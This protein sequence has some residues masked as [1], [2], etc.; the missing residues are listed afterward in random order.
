MHRE[1]DRRDGGRPRHADERRGPPRVDVL[2]QQLRVG[3]PRL[4]EAQP[5]AGDRLGRG[6]VAQRDRA[7][8]RPVVEHARDREEVG[9]PV[10]DRDVV[11]GG[12][13]R[14][15]RGELD[16]GRVVAGQDAERDDGRAPVLHEA[17]ARARQR[18]AGA[19]DGHLDDGRARLRRRQVLQGDRARVSP[20]VADHRDH[21]VQHDRGDVAA[22]E[23]GRCRPRRV[24]EHRHPAVPLLLDRDGA[25][26]RALYHRPPC[27][28]PREACFSHRRRSRRL[29]P[30]SPARRSRTPRPPA[31]GSAARASTP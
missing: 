13:R 27:L 12:H 17:C 28:T 21:R 14:R 24:E 31:A 16:S 9:A 23:A 5:P 3:R 10:E 18:A 20:P 26:E 2:G 19:L 11:R 15:R 1:V 6:S 25:V 4:L 22:V 30:R 8:R 29:T 7:D